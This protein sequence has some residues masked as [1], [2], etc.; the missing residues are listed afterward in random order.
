MRTGACLLASAVTIGLVVPAATASPRQSDAAAPGGTNLQVVITDNDTYVVGPTTFGAGRVNLTIDNSRD[1]DQDI[2]VG[3]LH[4]GYSWKRFRHDLKVAFGNLFA[5]NGDQAKG[6][7]ALN[8]MIDN[9]DA[10]GG[11]I[12][13]GGKTRTFSTQLT[14]V[15][16]RYFVFNNTRLPKQ[17]TR[18]HITSAAAPQ[19]LP[20]SGGTVIAKTNRRFDGSKVLPAKGRIKFVNRSTESPH[21]LE[22]QH[23]KEGTTRK[24][25]RQ[26]LNSDQQPDFLLPG[27][28]D[29]DILTTNQKMTF[30]VNLP[31]GE[32]VEMC[33][34]PDPKEGTPHALMGMIRI[35]HLK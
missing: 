32:Y 18:L 20:K 12:V 28:L 1:G 23:V 21:F 11:L 16:G 2:T 25:V 22:L 13:P 10:D 35:V 17:R 29:T 24:D 9:V 14:V 34:F 3:R 7:K 27:E 8:H 31:P 4:D 6:L 33:F 26:A 19:E 30:H 15:G 5:P